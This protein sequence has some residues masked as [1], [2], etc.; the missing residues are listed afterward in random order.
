MNEAGDP[1]DIIWGNIGGTRGIYF[2]R[3]FLFNLLG[4][5][6]IFYLST[7]AAIYSSLKMI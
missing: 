5:A 3:K 4:L 2:I 7:P 6:L 1:V